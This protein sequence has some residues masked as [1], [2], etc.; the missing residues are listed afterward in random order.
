VS[1]ELGREVDGVGRLREMGG[2]GGARKRGQ[3]A[4]LKLG[5]G[6]L[7]HGC[8]PPSAGTQEAVA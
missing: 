6:H 7:I 1:R 2:A 4:A 8:V 5:S 3:A